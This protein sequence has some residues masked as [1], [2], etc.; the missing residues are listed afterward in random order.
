M[1]QQIRFLD[2]W[3]IRSKNPPKP[4]YGMK[5]TWVGK[6][7]QI[8]KCPFCETLPRVVLQDAEYTAAAGHQVF[9]GKFCRVQLYCNN[10]G[11]PYTVYTPLEGPTLNEVK[12][13]WDQHAR[14]GGDQWGN[15]KLELDSAQEEWK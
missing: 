6:E 15:V 14:S 11:C 10:V 13:F 3:Q 12:A 9:K 8:A 7:I 1:G 4:V 5:K 2:A